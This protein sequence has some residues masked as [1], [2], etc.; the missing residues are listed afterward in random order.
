MGQRSCDGQVA[1]ETLDRVDADA[2]VK[3]CAIAARLARV[4]ADASVNGRERVV[5][6]QRFPRLL[7][8]ARLRMR[9]PR[10]DVLAGRARVIARRQQIH[11]HRVTAADRPHHLAPGQVDWRAHVVSQP[12]IHGQDSPLE[13]LRPASETCI[14]GSDSLGGPPSQ[15]EAEDIPD[16]RASWATAPHA[17]VNSLII[18]TWAWQVRPCPCETPEQGVRS[19]P[20]ASR[21]SW[22]AV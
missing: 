12:V 14:Q 1:E 6:D 5:A 11:I 4:I 17:A 3:V 18:R 15:L 16:S 10:L 13:R 9:E 21:S 2:A 7:E 19:Q 8:A 20:R 22:E